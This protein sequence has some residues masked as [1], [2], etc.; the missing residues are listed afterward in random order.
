[1]RRWGVKHL[2]V[3]TDATRAYLAASPSYVERWRDGLWA[4]FELVAADVRS[5]TTASGLGSAR[6]ANLDFLG[7]DVELQGVSTGDVVV[8]RG[9]YYPAWRARVGARAVALFAHGGQ[10]A[11]RVPESGTYTV[12]LDYPTYRGLSLLALVSFLAGCWGLTRLVRPR[13][14]D[15][16]V[17]QPRGA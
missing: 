4:D 2:L 6:L 17:D 7:A 3:W 5:A 9:N 11:F 15:G 14:H 1:M 8:L 13:G 16:Q 12:R 10:L